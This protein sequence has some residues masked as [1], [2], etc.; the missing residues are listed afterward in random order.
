MEAKFITKD[1]LEKWLDELSSRFE[2]WAP[3]KQSEGTKSVILYRPLGAGFQMELERKPTESAK[4]TIFPR[5]EPLLRYSRG[6]DPERSGAMTL[7]LEEAEAPAPR[8]VFGALPCDV[9]GFLVMDPVYNGSGTGGNA[10]DIYYLRRREKTVLISKACSRVLNSCFCHWVGGDPASSEGSDVLAQETDNGY[11]L[12]PITEKGEAVLDSSL[13]TKPSDA[14]K[15]QANKKSEAARAAL[16]EKQELTNTVEAL[17][18]KFSDSAFW[19]AESGLCLSCGA[20]TYLCPTCY[21][22][23]ITDESAGSKGIRIRSWDACMS[24]LFTEE[25]SGHNPRTSKAERLRN[26]VGHKFSYYPNIHEKMIA[27]VGCGRCIKSCPSGV[28]IRRIVTDALGL[29]PIVGMKEQN[30]V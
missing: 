3:C 22:F 1:N 23:N 19:Q 27:C 6:N 9:R 13:L 5:S 29:T 28:D 21:C 7:K 30:N 10:K 8:L 15:D 4:N 11:L 24:S 26:R 25:A 17:L 18:G 20:C 12:T 14:A 16:G 2:V